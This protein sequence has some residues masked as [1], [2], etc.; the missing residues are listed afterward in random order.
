[1]FESA[2]LVFLSSETTRTILLTGDSAGSCLLS[3]TAVPVVTPPIEASSSAVITVQPLPTSP[4]FTVTAVD[5]TSAVSIVRV[6]FGRRVEGKGGVAVTAQSMAVRV[7]GGKGVVGGV[8][9]VQDASDPNGFVLTVRYA[10]PFVPGDVLRVDVVDVVGTPDLVPVASAP[11]DLVLRNLEG[12]PTFVVTPASTSSAPARV[13]V[14]FS[15]EVVLSGALS[16][17]SLALTV[18]LTSKPG[19]ATT[20]ALGDW[21]VSSSTSSTMAL[22]VPF[23]GVST[24]GSYFDVNVANGAVLAADDKTAVG[25]RARRVTLM[26]PAGAPTFT[27]TFTVANPLLA[28]VT[29]SRPV[30]VSQGASSFVA[31]AASP[32][33]FSSSSISV[34]AVSTV[35][36][37]GSTTTSVQLSIPF[38]PADLAQAAGSTISVDVVSGAVLADDDRSVVS[39]SAV[40]VTLFNP[41]GPP[42]FTLTTAKPPVAT[43]VTATLTFSRPV[44][45]MEAQTV[46]VT[47]GRVLEVRATTGPAVYDVLIDL[48]VGAGPGFTIYVGPTRAVAAADDG[49]AVTQAGLPLIV[50]NGDGPPTFAALVLGNAT[51]SVTSV[52]LTFSRAVRSVSGGALSASSDLAVAI[53]TGAGKVGTVT[54][55][56]EQNG[57]TVYTLAVRYAV[58]FE[59]GALL[60]V[61][62]VK[63]RI[64]A[65]DDQ[66][67]VVQDAVVSRLTN[68]LCEIQPE[69]CLDAL[70]NSFSHLCTC[71]LQCN[72]PTSKV[73]AAGTVPSAVSPAQ[74]QVFS[75]KES[76]NV[77]CVFPCV[78]PATATPSANGTTLPAPSAAPAV[79]GSGSDGWREVYN[80]KPVSGSDL[81]ARLFIALSPG[82]QRL[83]LNISS[84]LP[85][86]VTATVQG[87]ALVASGS[88]FSY[89]K[90]GVGNFSRSRVEVVLAAA[91]SSSSSSSGKAAQPPFVWRV[92]AALE[93]SRVDYLAA[94]VISVSAVAA[95]AVALVLCSHYTKVHRNRAL[96]PPL[97]RWDQHEETT[98]A[99]AGDLTDQMRA[100]RFAVVVPMEGRGEEQLAGLGAVVGG[101]FAASGA[102]SAEVVAAIRAHREEAI[103]GHAAATTPWR[104]LAAADYAAVVAERALLWA[105]AAACVTVFYIMLCRVSVRASGRP[106]WPVKEYGEAFRDLRSTT[107]YNCGGLLSI[108][109]PILFSAMAVLSWLFFSQSAVFRG[110]MKLVGLA[111]SGAAA[112]RFALNE[113]ARL[114][115]GAF[116]VALALLALLFGA[117]V[118]FVLFTQASCSE[119]DRRLLLAGQPLAWAMLACFLAVTWTVW[120][121]KF[122]VGPD[123][124][125]WDTV[126]YIVLGPVRFCL[127]TCGVIT[128][129][130]SEAYAVRETAFLYDDSPEDADNQHGLVS[131]LL[132]RSRAVI[133]AAVPYCAPLYVLAVHL[134]SPPCF[135]LTTWQEKST[136]HHQRPSETHVEF[137]V[138]PRWRAAQSLLGAAHFAAIMVAATATSEAT[139]L[140][141]AIYLAVSLAVQGGLGAALHL[142]S[143]AYDR[144]ISRHTRDLAPGGK[145]QDLEHGGGSPATSS[146][147]SEE[148]LAWLD[149][150]DDDDDDTGGTSNAYPNSE[151]QSES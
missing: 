117:Y 57:L 36:P 142:R 144:L 112:K 59:N 86:L 109:S 135:N 137:F 24:P 70:V 106:T 64:A 139:E 136:S 97:G 114:L 103:A 11:V 96:V 17:P 26:N 15:R 52:R 104:E 10:T 25:P 149:A 37:I 60:S 80:R 118:R 93:D 119:Y 32:S 131:E 132:V 18:A 98:A 3:I 87:Q 44:R 73:C 102:H 27:V 90:E 91:A 115:S 151:G 125:W 101:N 63:G 113:L 4:G 14:V 134:A 55:Q 20:M 123:A 128:N 35:S 42:T 92:D 145:D 88:S 28:T 120:T 85:G 40:S 49:A 16:N 111:R 116:F 41:S 110:W 38:T 79:V 5:V 124:P 69:N 148:D 75:D 146:R 89:L 105:P 72:R 46:A 84:G 100:P 2:T 74:G 53:I 107:V 76:F 7:V 22:L 83:S 43:P 65:L 34:S 30:I 77:A 1:L 54:I 94:I 47:A 122:L 48:P 6:V 9:V 141:A 129:G 8:T 45:G 150:D 12:P 67:R 51:A 108:G 19:A 66:A 126:L 133:W 23:T 143:M 121:G 58:P 130:V 140:K 62:A 68:G 31:T 147:S 13:V 99:E 71:T 82:N 78:A 39:P 33:S 21:S 56:S 95:V 138:G 50:L 29:F 127:L 61:S 81:P